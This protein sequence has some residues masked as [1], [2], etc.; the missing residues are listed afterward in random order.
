M[1]TATMGYTS[2]ARDKKVCDNTVCCRYPC[3][4]IHGDRWRDDQLDWPLRD[5]AKEIMPCGWDDVHC[6]ATWIYEGTNQNGLID[7]VQADHSPMMWTL[8]AHYL[9]EWK[10]HYNPNF[11]LRCCTNPKDRSTCGRFDV[12]Y[13]AESVQSA[14][15]EVMLDRPDYPFKDGKPYTLNIRCKP[16]GPI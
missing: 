14:W 2:M 4:G 16:V 11:K 15:R 9:F 8:P 6:R 3:E 5:E 12:D 10:L 7:M 1:N 13:P